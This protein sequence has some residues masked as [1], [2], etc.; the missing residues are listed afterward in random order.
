MSAP[1][2]SLRRTALLR[3]SLLQR[4]LAVFVGFA[5]L[6]ALLLWAGGNWLQRRV[7]DQ[8]LDRQRV[9]ALQTFERA[10]V[11]LASQRGFREPTPGD[12]RAQLAFCATAMAP[13]PVAA[14]AGSAGACAGSDAAEELACNLR[15]IDNRLAAMSGGYQRGGERLLTERYVVSVPRWVEAIRGARG[16]ATPAGAA[17]PDGAGQA[18]SC[19][20]A[21][22]AARDLAAGD[23]R[24]L[25]LLAW[26]ERAAGG[27]ARRFA[28]G[29]QVLISEHILAQHN[30]WSGVPGCVYYGSAPLMF[31]SDARQANRQACFAMRPA[32]VAEKYLHAAIDGGEDSPPPSLQTILADLDN[33]RL[34]GRELFRAYTQA[35]GAAGIESPGAGRVL[36]VSLGPSGA[37]AAAPAARV[38]RPHGP[39]QLERGGHRVDAGFNIQLTIDPH[40]QRAAQ[41]LSECYAGNV[42]ACRAAGLADDDAFN[43]LRKL[44]YEQAAVRMAAVALIDVASGRIEAL[45]SAHSDC[46]REEFDGS[47]RD[48][49]CPSL[50]ATKSHYEPD[51]LLNH[52]L[53]TD[54]LPGS[55]IKPIMATAFLSDPGYRARILSQRVSGN[56]LRLQD[57]LK[58]SDSAA[59]LDRMFC[60]DQ[61]W[62]RCERPRQV[63]A[64]A[65]LFH[66]DEGC[67]PA[68]SRCGRLNA[69]FGYPEIVR[70]R[71]DTESLPLGVSVL[72]GRLLTEPESSARAADYQLMGNFAFDPRAAAACSR[73]GFY[74][75]AGNG[76]WRRCHQ[77]H[78]TYLESEGWGQGN[79]R[80]TALGAAGMVARLA[81]AANGQAAE[82]LPH[83]VEYISDAQAQPFATAAEQFGL[84]DALKVDIPQDA[85]ALILGGMLAHKSAGSPPGSRSGT[86]HV[87]CA[88]VFGAAAC[89]RIDWIAGK[90]GTPPYG[91]DGL[92]LR[93]IAVQCGQTDH[94]RVGNPLG[95]DAL[96]ACTHERPYKWYLAAFRTDDR[97]PGFDKAVAVLTERNWYRAG[98]QAGKVQSPGDTDGLNLS[99]EIAFR[100]MA[101]LR[102]APQ[103]PET[104][105]A[106]P[107]TTSAETKSASPQTVRIA[108]PSSGAGA[109]PARGKGT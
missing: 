103:A 7:Q 34:P 3:T 18:I 90:T 26:R 59:F 99:A 12:L 73:G 84:A 22:K 96:A 4:A 5:L 64:A 61:G 70:V 88:R 40:A 67:A 66:W 32:G 109:S 2:T 106:M 62:S 53:Y 8:Y 24:L 101:A 95:A 86:A 81:A 1:R 51:R 37:D 77:G 92:T 78:L 10:I 52:A 97:L 80:T 68:S 102:V 108:S 13:R 11:P 9:A 23:G 43:Q 107:A 74:S 72:Y 60:S 14:S 33:I 19:T 56:F 29:Q 63:Q 36:P 57:E 69:L 79:A 75:G 91:N 76:A 16:D 94:G 89:D 17:V 45:A 28:P 27:A 47:G 85:A 98:P 58:S 41:Q 20:A 54:A 15:R 82:R 39:N 25:D 35:P 6:L 83:L 104:A 105:A 87:S 42:R 38:A 44:M 93:Q 48:G 21:V 65:R 55:I 31:V 71:D 46:Y 100:I 30:P 49:R 50:P